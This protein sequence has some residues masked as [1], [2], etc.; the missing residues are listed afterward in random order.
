MSKLS[1]NDVMEKHFSNTK[2]DKKFY[3][4]LMNFRISWGQKSDDYITF[5][6]TNL[7]GTVVVRFSEMDESNL[8][9]DV[10]NVDMNMLQSDIY[11]LD[12]IDK[13]WNVGS[14]ATYLAIGY[15]MH[16]FATDGILDKHTRDDAI[17]EAYYV[18]AYKVMG[19]LIS[20]YFTYPVSEPIAKAV[21]ERLS[22]RYLIKKLSS[23]QEL[24]KYRSNDFLHK[25]LHEK[26]VLN[27][28]TDDAVRIVTD[29]QGRLRETIKNIYI[30][31]IDV[32]DSNSKI[33]S[34]TLV[35]EGEGGES[36]KSVENV[37]NMILNVHA[38][39]KYKYDF[40][41]DNYIH[42]V[43][44]MMPNLDA[45]LLK[46]TLGFISDHINF[47]Q[48]D[49]DDFISYTLNSA[50]AYLTT[51]GI[52]TGYEDRLLEEI[53]MLKGYW[54]SSSVKDP[55]LKH[56]KGLLTKYTKHATGK[57]TKWMITTVAIGV[58]CYIFVLAVAKRK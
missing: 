53:K 51:K 37:G 54:S 17:R 9:V 55:K 10:F 15:I 24:F 48:N 21:Y 19:S 23:W 58:M 3:K 32:K 2:F 44:V 1:I 27:Y 25:G 22:N 14:N 4:K 7:L 16:R 42:L 47:K 18:L 13:K 52:M 28:T 45:E 30:I 40:V 39:V 20:H 36:L 5:L 46:T 33:N 57:K 6:G 12:G 35:E 41:D 56:T 49:K 11:N 26:R 43:S 50:I 8:F 31:L 34:T 38:L 29:A